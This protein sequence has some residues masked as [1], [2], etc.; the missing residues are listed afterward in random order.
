MVGVV[1]EKKL[2][3]LYELQTLY[4]LEDLYNLY[5]IVTIRIANEQKQLKEAEE[6]AK[7]RK[8]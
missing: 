2:A 8:R 4:G 3:S 1:V 7:T 6:R 5:E